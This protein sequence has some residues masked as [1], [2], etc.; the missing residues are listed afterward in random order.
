MKK[1]SLFFLILIVFTVASITVM[2]GWSIVGSANADTIK[3]EPAVVEEEPSPIDEWWTS[4]GAWISTLVAAL[5]G[6]GAGIV[7]LFGVLVKAAKRI[8]TAVSGLN[9]GSATLDGVRSEVRA[10]K[11]EYMNDVKVKYDGV[12]EQVE[13]LINVVK[14]NEDKIASLEIMLVE[15]AKGSSEYVSNGTADKILNATRSGDEKV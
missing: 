15:M 14:E 11:N 9:D 12:C 4:N 5:A 1:N 13:T 3:D 8:G 7:A 2:S 10:V 6:V